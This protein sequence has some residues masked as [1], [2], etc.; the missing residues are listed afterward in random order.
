MPNPKGA[1]AVADEAQRAAELGA[2]W[3]PP[4]SWGKENNQNKL[5]LPLQKAYAEAAWPDALL[6]R[7]GAAI[8]GW[9]GAG[10]HDGLGADLLR[11]HR[12]RKLLG[13]KDCKGRL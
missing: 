9:A 5:W 13:A 7:I 4:Q 10:Q 1:T 11:K 12:T 3:K 8:Q 2:S 6:E